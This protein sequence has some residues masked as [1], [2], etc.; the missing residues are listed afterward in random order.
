[1]TAFGDKYEDLVFDID[2]GLDKM[3][4]GLDLLLKE[5]DPERHS[6]IRDGYADVFKNLEFSS[7]DNKEF[8]FQ[9]LVQA[10]D[11]SAPAGWWF[12]PEEEY[13]VLYRFCNEYP[14]GLQIGT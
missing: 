14:N 5:L 7:D 1:M 8:L 13:S 9:D 11:L 12:G 4:S 6:R 10:I 3:I 2:D